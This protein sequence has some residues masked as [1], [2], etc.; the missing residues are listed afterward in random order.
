MARS[1]DWQ[2]G[3]GKRKISKSD[4][5]TTQIRNCKISNWTFW[6]PSGPDGS[7]DHEAEFLVFRDNRA[8]LVAGIETI[9]DDLLKPRPGLIQLFKHYSKFVNEIRATFCCLSLGIVCC[10]G[11][12]GAQ[13]L[14]R[15]IAPLLGSWE[16]LRNSCGAGTEP[17]Q[18]LV[19]LTALFL[20]DCHADALASCTPAPD[21]SPI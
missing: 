15:D 9:C 11:K 20:V 21:I 17:N 3:Q 4:D 18:S 5:P 10:C 8:H 2:S 16:H 7:G 6:A 19:K 1:G 14:L 13:D 12:T